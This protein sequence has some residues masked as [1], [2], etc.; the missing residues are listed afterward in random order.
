[1]ASRLFNIAVICSTIICCVFAAA[2]FVADRIDPV[3]QFVGLGRDV[4]I[5]VDRRPYGPALEIFNDSAYG[6][7]TG[8][9]I[10]VSS[11]GK[12]SGIQ[13]SYFDFPGVYY[14]HFLWPD[15]TTL[16]TLSLSLIYLA[17]FSAVLPLTWCIARWRRKRGS[18]TIDGQPVAE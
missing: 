5:S 13:S 1:M 12:P 15:G 9:I 6:P 17:V 16:W 10:S 4:Q 11:P 8:S 7:Y 14:R 3:K 18:E 2:C